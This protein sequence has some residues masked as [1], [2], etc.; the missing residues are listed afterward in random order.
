M[1]N[2]AVNR[3]MVGLHGFEDRLQCR[4][5]AHCRFKSKRISF[6]SLR[7]VIKHLDGYRTQADD[8]NCR[9]TVRSSAT[10][11]GRTAYIRQPE[12]PRTASEIAS[13]VDIRTSQ[14]SRSATTSDAKNGERSPSLSVG[15]AATHPPA[16]QD[17]SL[18]VERR[19]RQ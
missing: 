17:G 12:Y 19:T 10:R 2:G 7:V 3:C 18:L 11:P 9:R 4:A 1:R 13:D 16:K 14:P 8:W 5:S 15:N 6:A